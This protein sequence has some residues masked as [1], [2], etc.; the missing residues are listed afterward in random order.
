MRRYGA[1]LLRLCVPGVGLEPT[2]GEPH[3]I[4]SVDCLPIPAPGH[5]FSILRPG[6]ESPPEADSPPARNPQGF[7]VPTGH[8]P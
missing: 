5:V 7:C 6:G 3:N 8:P 1:G 4:L 2:R